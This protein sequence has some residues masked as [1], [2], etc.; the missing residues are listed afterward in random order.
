MTITGLDQSRQQTTAE[1]IARL[2][3]N[4]E[5]DEMNRKILITRV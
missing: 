2:E 3:Q 5:I 1:I 4:Q